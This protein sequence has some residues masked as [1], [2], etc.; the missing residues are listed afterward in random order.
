MKRE[1]VT[2]PKKRGACHV[3]Q[4][5]RG[6][7]QGEAGCRGSE[8]KSVYCGFCG[9]EQVRQAKQ[10]QDWLVGTISVGSGAQGLFLCGSWPWDD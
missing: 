5:H 3:T 10:V 1:F 7:H 8:E 9:K 6:K 4:S 2:A